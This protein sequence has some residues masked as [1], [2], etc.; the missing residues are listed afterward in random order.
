M[1]QTPEQIAAEIRRQKARHPDAGMEFVYAIAVIRLADNRWT[2]D[3][4]YRDEARNVLAALKLVER[5]ESREL[6]ATVAEIQS[7]RGDG[8]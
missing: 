3:G 4:E 7:E 5:D 6:A 8:A 2:S 1:S